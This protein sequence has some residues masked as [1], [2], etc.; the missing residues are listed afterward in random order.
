M[1]KIREMVDANTIVGQPI[2]T[3][4]GVMLIP[5]SKIT[6]GFGTGGSDFQ[7]KNQT[8]NKDNPFGGGGGAGVN[9]I[10]VAFLVVKAD[11]VKVLPI[12]P[13]ASSTVDR[14]VEMM[15]EF[16]EKLPFLKKKKIEPTEE[17]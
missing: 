13:P 12:A 16:M 6:F 3:P 5:I 14:V 10:P 4:D 2:T 17:E 15:P 1:Q 11:S 7:T 8:A 9:I